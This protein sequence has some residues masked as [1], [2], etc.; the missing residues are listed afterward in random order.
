MQ[1]TLGVHKM[2]LS[3]SRMM[4]G[5]SGLIILT[6]AVQ[7]FLA[8]NS[9][10]SLKGEVKVIVSNR[11]PAFIELGQMNTDLS[12][13]RIAQG[14]L[15][16]AAPEARQGF[17]A[18]LDQARETV[19][20]S[21]KRYEPYLIDQ[22][23]RDYLQ[24]FK[25][26]L[27]AADNDWATVH[28]LI[29][30]GKSDDARAAFYGPSLTSY[31]AA[32][33]EL[34]NAVD[35]MG[36][37]VKNEGDYALRTTDS[38]MVATFSAMGVLFLIAVASAIFTSQYVSKPL[39]RVVRAMLSLA[40]G[41]I[42]ALVQKSNRKDEIGEIQGAL[43]VF[44]QAAVANKRL[45][46]E[47]AENRARSEI[48]R[49]ETQRK[50]EEDAAER[51]RI[52][53]SGLAS[54]LKRLASGDLSFQ[55]NDGFSSE[56]EA[57]RHDFNQSV[58]QLGTTLTE[59]SQSIVTM[60][61]GTREIAAGANDL[62]KRTENQ[63]ASLE[64]TA[65][66]LDEITANV[67]N[68]TKRTEEA[69]SV[70]TRANQSAV[71][72]AEVVSHAE[73]AMRKIE[74]SSQQISNIIGVIDEIAFQ[75]NLLA[76]N[77]G[78]EAARAGDAGKGFAV[79]AQEV[80]E[81]AQRSAQAAKEI[82]GLIR[83]SSSEVE[84]GVK[85]VLEASDSLKTIGSFIVE[86]NA[87]MDSIATSAREQSVGLAEVNGAVNGMD[88]MTQQ[89]AA[90]VEQ[91][92]AASSSLAQEALKLRDLVSQFQLEGGASAQSTALRQTGRAMAEPEARPLRAGRSGARAAGGAA[93]A[94][95]EEF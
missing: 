78:V 42:T 32:G 22:A 93:A 79:V 4:L 24:A 74:S 28:K 54:G 14:D 56:F 39:S 20:A 9:L 33:N 8:F 16:N 13:M 44:R 85:L 11:V 45:E 95:W 92:T 65:A 52:A 72:S 61:N 23:D 81:L 35:D 53:T 41:N 50:A 12:D 2:R 60:D 19:E 64:E 68:S 94:D 18:K 21:I 49:A 70:A 10:S 43:E 25:R 27:A 75:T 46:T 87:H 51:L 67:S 84:G 69:R 37:D 31:E 15:L 5:I 82:K 77:A 88:Q 83:N 86:M 1:V 17:E 47:A 40:D 55:L 7:A 36:G 34:Q 73:A 89:N 63:A 29:G 57:L 3:I 6:I 58:R 66:A 71:K 59:I 26:K 30:E 76:L 80:R 90:M 91:S 38:T 48:E 62:S